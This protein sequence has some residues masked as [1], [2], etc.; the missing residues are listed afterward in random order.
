M[1]GMFFLSLLM[2]YSY[3]AII[4]DE[5]SVVEDSFYFLLL[6]FAIPL[7]RIELIFL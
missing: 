3:C 7:T 1:V 4:V 5:P 6:V 2:S